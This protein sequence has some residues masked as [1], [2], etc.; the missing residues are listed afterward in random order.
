MWRKTKEL[1]SVSVRKAIDFEIGTQGAAIAFYTIFSVAPLLILIISVGSL[2]YSE[3]LI[4]GQV[5]EQ[6]ETYFGAELAR[7]LQE[8]MESRKQAAGNLF[9]SIVALI[10][11]AVGATTVISQLKHVL[12][13]IWNVETIHIHSVWQFMLNRLISFGIIIILSFL[14]LTSLFAE[15]FI[16]FAFSFLQQI[17]PEISLT[18]YQI[19][20]QM[21]TI[22]FAIIFFTLVFK[23]L[24]DVHARWSDIL[25][26]ALFT[27]ILFLLG[28][29]L[30]GLFLTATGIDTTYRAAGSIVIFVIWVY[31][32]VQIVLFGA[33]VTQVYTSMFGGKILPYKFVSLRMGK[34]Q[35]D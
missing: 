20:S 33:I 13:K 5:S 22:F 29:Y 30:V 2:F 19:L 9:T 35:T 27:T 18:Y 26:G 8:F 17:F 4:T 1:I 23:I 24:P 25:A 10:T 34:T 7:G 28:K 32:N 6:L 3:E 11:M 12:N 21:S 14:L 15:S 16:A 31:Y